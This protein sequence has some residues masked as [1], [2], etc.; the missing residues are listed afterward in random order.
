MR[1]RYCFCSS[2]SRQRSASRILDVASKSAPFESL[3]K[4]QGV[5]G[6][7]VGPYAG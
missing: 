6:I 4:L 1:G 2:F 3:A 7:K 5:K